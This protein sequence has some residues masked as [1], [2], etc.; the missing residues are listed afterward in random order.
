MQHLDQ[1]FLGV[2]DHQTAE[3]GAEDDDHLGWLPEHAHIAI[4]HGVAAQHATDD[5]EGT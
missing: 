2:T 4:G 5:D 3:R 1:D